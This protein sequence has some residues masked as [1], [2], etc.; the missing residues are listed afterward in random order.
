VVARRPIVTARTAVYGALVP[1]PTDP[2][3]RDI[4]M[5]CMRKMCSWDIPSEVLEQARKDILAAKAVSLQIPINRLNLAEMTLPEV[6]M[7]NPQAVSAST[8][9]STTSLPRISVC[10]GVSLSW[11]CH[12]RR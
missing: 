10:T 3:K 7:F 5:A 9:L 2:Q 6:A 4:Y 12:G 1:E 11:K 8:V